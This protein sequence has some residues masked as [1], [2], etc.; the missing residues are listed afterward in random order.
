MCVL[1]ILLSS[2]FIVLVYFTVYHLYT[3]NKSLS[4]VDTLKKQ[5][6]D[7]NM[8]NVY[9]YKELRKSDSDLSKCKYTNELKKKT[10]LKNLSMVKNLSIGAS[11]LIKLQN[12]KILLGR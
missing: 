11:N 7:S 6:S 1:Q 2:L 10:E 9:L 3:C 12:N 4:N 8:E 5:I